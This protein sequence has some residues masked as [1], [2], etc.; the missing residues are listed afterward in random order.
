MIRYL[1][2]LVLVTVVLGRGNSDGSSREN[3][4]EVELIDN[5]NY[6]LKLYSYNSRNEDNGD[7]NELHGDIKMVTKEGKSISDRLEYGWCLQMNDQDSMWDCMRIRTFL[8]PDR[9]STNVAW[10]STFTIEDF[11]TRFPSG[12]LVPDTDVNILDNKDKNWLGIAGKSNK[13]CTKIRE[14]P[15]FT[16]VSCNE[17]NAHF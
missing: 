14:F 1:I 12:V 16:F 6:T 15:E 7:V 4:F 3:A 5:E 17:I 8:N 2:A 10:A 11:H 9:A 13:S